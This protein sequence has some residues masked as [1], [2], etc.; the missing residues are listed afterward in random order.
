MNNINDAYEYDENLDMELYA[1]MQELRDEFYHQKPVTAL[2]LKPKEP[3]VTIEVFDT[4]ECWCSVI[5]TDYIIHHLYDGLAV[6]MH[7]ENS[8]LLQPNLRLY[9]PREEREVLVHGSLI[10]TGLC[11]SD[12]EFSIPYEGPWICSINEYDIQKLADYI[13]DLDENHGWGW[14]Q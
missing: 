10:V 6:V 3:P 7:S 11:Y 5:G 4:D 1:A 9:L 8:N 13:R 2:L 12:L 14:R